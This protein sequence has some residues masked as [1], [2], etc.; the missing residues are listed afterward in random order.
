MQN[1]GMI[2]PPLNHMPRHST[3]SSILMAKSA[4]RSGLLSTSLSISPPEPVNRHQPN[5][6]TSTANSRPLTITHTK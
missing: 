4:D 1:D 6:V 5:T 2:S 3:V